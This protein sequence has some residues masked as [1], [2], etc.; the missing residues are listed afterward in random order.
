MNPFFTEGMDRHDLQL[1]VKSQDVCTSGFYGF[2][3]PQTENLWI[4]S[5]TSLNNTPIRSRRGQIYRYR[6]IGVWVL[7]RGVKKSRN[8]NIANQIA[9]SILT[10]FAQRAT[11]STPIY[12]THSLN[13]VQIKDGRVS[14]RFGVLNPKMLFHEK[15]SL[16]FK[17]RL[18]YLLKILFRI[19]KS[20]NK[21]TN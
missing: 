20:K 9:K 17:F 2:C 12:R 18:N 13:R 5:T 1:S 14:V 3:K 7:W 15:K 8:V 10:V 16:F 21:K 19:I 11:N 4:F 6:K